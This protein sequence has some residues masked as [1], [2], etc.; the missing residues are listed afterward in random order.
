MALVGSGSHAG[1]GQA[2]G[3]ARKRVSAYLTITVYPYK[4]TQRELEAR[5]EP[6]LTVLPGQLMRF[7]SGQSVYGQ[8]KEVRA[9]PPASAGMPEGYGVIISLLYGSPTLEPQRVSLL[10][11]SQMARE[12]Q[13][14]QE[15]FEKP[16]RLTPGF[17][18][19][20]ARLGT[21][22]LIEGH[23]FL[24][25]YEA[26]L[27]LLNAVEPYRKLLILDPLGIF[28]EMDGLEYRKA[29]QDLQLSVQ[30]VGSKRFL[31]AFGELFAPDLREQVLRVVADHLPLFAKFIGFHDLLNL[32]AAVNV[33]LK[34][35]ILQNYHTVTQAHIFA[36]SPEQ[37]FDASQL[38]THPVVALDM[39]ELESPWKSL[40][41]EQICGEVLES[42]GKVQEEVVLVL[43]YPENYLSDLTGWV[44]KAEEAGL[45]LLVLTSPYV[46][47][48]VGKLANNRILVDAK[49]QVE[50]QGDLTL[51]LPVQLQLSDAIPTPEP[52]TS[53]HQSTILEQQQVHKPAE[54]KVDSSDEP[55]SQ[56]P[57]SI[58]T[59]LMEEGVSQLAAPRN[60]AEAA[61]WF[62]V[63]QPLTE[64]EPVPDEMEEQAPE[65]PEPEEETQDVGPIV[66][67]SAPE[68]EPTI[69]FL[70]A[71]QLSALLA[72]SAEGEETDASPVADWNELVD[73]SD[74]E[75][76]YP[77]AEEGAWAEPPV[78]LS[79][80]ELGPPER[81][82]AMPPLVEPLDDRISAMPESSEEVVQSHEPQV[83]EE[84]P[85]A[86]PP[87]PTPEE[88]RKDEFDF[89]LNLD[90]IAVGTEAE[91]GY[92]SSYLADG[93]RLPDSVAKSLSEFEGTNNAK[94]EESLF[95]FE[96]EL[97][98]SEPVSATS[99]QPE[100]EPSE[101]E[102]PAWQSESEPQEGTSQ[103]EAATN[104]DM[105]DDEDLQEAL[106]LIFPHE[107]VDTQPA[108]DASP[109][110]ESRKSRPAEDEPVPI[111]P[112]EVD[113]SLEEQAGFQVGD[114]VRHPSY[115]TGTVQ[116][117]IPM[118][119]SVVL[120]ITFDTVG[121]RLLDPSLTELSLEPG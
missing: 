50:L 52:V 114:K 93:E 24:L 31:S 48:A 58:P 57:E 101:R 119:D 29:G 20:L 37:A 2:D 83:V 120:N 82:T 104:P 94:D 111:V 85:A 92:Y 61:W 16:V 10:D 34:N 73:T 69:S 116:R 7:E 86:P 18:G 79:P 5:L 59:E 55:V 60:P 47:R 14:L 95:D 87:F 100:W 71:E 33:P 112:K 72:S 121:K 9:M 44:Q 109:K 13:R 43:L 113:A 117:I 107:F 23:D 1:C 115:G 26:L 36:D 38:L 17:T 62:E 35:L 64:D 22:S 6:G 70:T 63:S 108:T 19:E 78:D 110:P 105:M 68:P 98:P 25:K 21:L 15:P 39:S 103:R 90:E 53:L 45:S 3:A 77:D 75:L 32:D 66:D 65:Q 88:Y 81:Q 11:A 41:Y 80:P 97:Y 8:V 46:S 56:E 89:E 102:A 67:L 12:V 30:A 99:G 74:D 27:L 84:E 40:F 76:D 91:S 49:H 96:S 118:E 4:L 51:G 42:M 106:D 28:E 54:P